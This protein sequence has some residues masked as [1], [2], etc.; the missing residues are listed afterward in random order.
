L[1]DLKAG[2]Q[3]VDVTLIQKAINDLNW[4]KSD[5]GFRKANEAELARQSNFL[6]PQIIFPIFRLN[7]HAASGNTK[8]RLRIINTNA[9]NGVYFLIPF[10][11]KKFIAPAYNLQTT[12]ASKMSKF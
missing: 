1:I 10:Y 7:S 6:N 12:M 4:Q 3:K 11:L 2:C 8:K 5:D 9:I